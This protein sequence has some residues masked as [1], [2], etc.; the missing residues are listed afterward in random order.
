MELNQLVAESLADTKAS[1]WLDGPGPFG[2]ELIL[3]LTILVMLLL[4]LSR[5]TS[6]LNA[7]WVTLAGSLAAL[8]F[9]N[10]AAHLSGDGLDRYELFTGM[11]VY[12]SFAVYVRALLILFAALFA[13]FTR[14]SG[15]PDKADNADFYCLILGATIGMCLMASANHLLVVFLAVEMA[16]VPSYALAAT[17]KGRREAS[18]AALKYAV[19]GAGAAGVMLYGI[20]LIAGLLNTL[21]FPTLATQ[22]AVELP[23]MAGPQKMVLALSALMIAVGLAF[24]LSAVPFH[25]WCPDVFEGASAEVDAFLSVASKAGALALLVRVCLG[26]GL[27]PAQ[28]QGPPSVETV[29]EV[30]ALTP[31]PTGIFSVDDPLQLAAVESTTSDEAGSAEAVSNEATADKG[32]NGTADGL[33]P[34]RMFIALLIAFLA[35]ITSTF[36]NLAAYAQTNIKRLLAYSTIAHAGYMMLPLPVAMLA[37]KSHPDVAATGHRF[38][39]PVHGILLVHESG[40]VRHRGLS[41]QCAAQ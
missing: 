8:Y 22:L 34:V 12:D 1:L 39:G 15:I 19:Y 33:S 23:N 21:H 3:S 26:I 27:I 32:P 35:A 31:S 4:K 40:R 11:L 38:A 16:S 14:I 36:G 18:E 24:K 20:S 13:I 29:V 2:P 10:P 30:A 28:V 9:A 25:F 6:R 41:A 17:L 37:A 5:L 7:F